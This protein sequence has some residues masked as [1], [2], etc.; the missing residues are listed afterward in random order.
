VRKTRANTDVTPLF[1]TSLSVAYAS[2]VYK[3]LSGVHFVLFYPVLCFRLVLSSRTRTPSVRFRLLNLHSADIFTHCNLKIPLTNE[4]KTPI[5]I[6]R[7]LRLRR[8]F[9]I[10]HSFHFFPFSYFSLLS[11]LPIKIFVV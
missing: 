5:R 4:A 2:L 3:F 11:I 6:L 8:L 1:A 10:L 9:L 7:Y